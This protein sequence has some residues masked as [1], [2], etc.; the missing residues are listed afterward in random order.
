MSDVNRNVFVNA[1]GVSLLRTIYAAHTNTGAPESNWSRPLV[2]VADPNGP[3]VMYGGSG[4]FDADFL[5][6][7]AV[8]SEMVQLA[9][10]AGVTTDQTAVTAALANHDISDLEAESPFAAMARL[11]IRFPPDP[12]F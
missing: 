7:M 8:P 4:G 1:A 2:T 6:A 3:V 10:N 12:E 11:G 9:F 5:A